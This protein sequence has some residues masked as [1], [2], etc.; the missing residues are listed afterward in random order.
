MVRKF[1]TRISIKMQVSDGAFGQVSHLIFVICSMLALILLMQKGVLVI[2]ISFESEEFQIL[3][4]YS[5]G[6]KGRLRRKTFHFWSFSSYFENDLINVSHFK[7]MILNYHTQ[8]T[9]EDE[10]SEYISQLISHEN[11]EV[12]LKVFEFQSINWVIPSINS[13]RYLQSNTYTDNIFFT[14]LKFSSFRVKTRN[15][16]KYFILQNF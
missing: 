4:F 1:T 12:S 16:E 10:N 7:S 5:L 3:H 9:N 8:E 15:F 2:L 11:K 6:D 14:T 13:L